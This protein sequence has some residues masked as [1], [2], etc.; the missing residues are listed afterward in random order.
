[1]PQYKVT[2]I[3]RASASEECIGSI[4]LAPCHEEARSI[5]RRCAASYTLHTLS[6]KIR[7]FTLYQ[8][9]PSFKEVDAFLDGENF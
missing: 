8:V 1:M 2:V 4:F 9:W 3:P 7:V 5:A 6:K